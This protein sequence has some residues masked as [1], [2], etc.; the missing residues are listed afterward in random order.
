MGTFFYIGIIYYN[1]ALEMYYLYINICKNRYFFRSL[2]N[3]DFDS[4][5]KE[6]EELF[7]TETSSTYYVPPI[8]KKY[9]RNNIINQ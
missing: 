3:E 2:K 5:S 1:N 4:L 7:P 9:S 8:T 6:I